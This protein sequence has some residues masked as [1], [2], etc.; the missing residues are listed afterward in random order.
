LIAIPPVLQTDPIFWIG[1]TGAKY[2]KISCRE[3]APSTFI[4]ASDFFELAATVAP[5]LFGMTSG[6]ALANAFFWKFL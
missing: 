4:G 1:H 5:V 6:A 3:A 2:L